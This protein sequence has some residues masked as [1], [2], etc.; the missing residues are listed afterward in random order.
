MSAA[1]D[2]DRAIEACRKAGVRS[3]L[4]RGDTDF[5]QTKHLDR[6]NR[7]GDIRFLFGLDA[8]SNLI[9]WAED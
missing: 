9:A 5:T 6:W 7:A 4:L 8:R 3:L 1:L 2:L